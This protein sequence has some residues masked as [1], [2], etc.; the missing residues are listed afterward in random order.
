[1]STS[2]NIQ[3]YNKEIKKYNC[4]LRVISIKTIKIIFDL[5]IDKLDKGKTNYEQE[6]TKLEKKRDIYINKYCQLIKK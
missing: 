6:K 5:L 4:E 2:Y 3:I 1:M